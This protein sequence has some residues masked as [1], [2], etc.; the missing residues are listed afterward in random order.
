MRWQGKGAD[1]LTTVDEQGRIC[2]LRL[3]GLGGRYYVRPEGPRGRNRTLPGHPRD[4]EPA[5]ALV[6]GPPAE[7]AQ[8]A[9]GAANERLELERRLRY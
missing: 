4:G 5:R 2:H 3:A 7:R 1:L 9:A 8:T 6:E